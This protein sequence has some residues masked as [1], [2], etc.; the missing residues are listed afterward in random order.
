MRVFISISIPE[1]AKREIVKIQKEIDRLGLVKGKFTEP[2]NLHLTL[3]F[4]GE[5]SEVEIRAVK[6]RLSKLFFEPFEISFNNLGVFSEDFIRII[7]IGISGE[8]EQ[9]F[10]LQAKIDYLLKDLFPLENRFM[11]HVT[12][13]RPK[14]I[15]DKRIF[16]DEFKKI[17]IPYI[18]F[19]VDKVYLNESKLSKF[20]VE[21]NAIGVY[22]AVKIKEISV[23]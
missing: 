2:D 4:L 9:I 8:N 16:L 10:S 1:Y 15:E 22:G 20:G 21:Y 19:K 18:H 14:N 3:K 17:K 6:E 11:G 12:I 23:Q 13:A 7:W 5:I